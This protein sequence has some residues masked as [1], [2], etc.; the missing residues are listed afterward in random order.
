MRKVCFVG[1]N[2]YELA[3][4]MMKVCKQS[5]RQYK[6][7]VPDKFSMLCELMYFSST[8]TSCTFDTQVVSVSSLAYKVLD[9]L[10]ISIEVL[11][12]QQQ[13]LLV[14]KAIQN[15]GDKLGYIKKVNSSG[16][17]T[18]MSKTI[19]Q[20]K[21]SNVDLSKLQFED[22]KIN[23]FKMI[24]EEYQKL[25]VGKTDNNDLIDLLQKNL[26]NSTIFENT[27]FL[28]VGFDSFT[29][30]IFEVVKT[31]SEVCD[32]YVGAL[33]PPNQ[34]QKSF[35]DLDIYQ[36]VSS[37]FCDVE[38]VM[39]DKTLNFCQAHIE[40]NLFNTQKV[41]T[42]KD[43]LKVYSC[44]AFEDEVEFAFCQ[45]ANSLKD[46]AKPSEISV[47]V[48]NL[49]AHI[50]VLWEKANMYD[51]PVHIEES[52][53]LC[54][55]TLYKFFENIFKLVQSG[56]RAEYIKNFW[57]S[58]FL[59]L[60]IFE[61]GTLVGCCQQLDFFEENFF[62][63]HF[64]TEKYDFYAQYLKDFAKNIKNCK[65]YQQF[66]TLLNDALVFFDCKNRL[67]VFAQQYAQRGFIREEKIFLQIYQKYE[68]AI[69]NFVKVSQDE[70]FDLTSFLDDFSVF[71]Q[72]VKI[73][74]VPIKANSIYVGDATDD[75]F[76]HVKTLYILGAS[77]DSL[78]KSVYDCGLILDKDISSVEG[79][80][81]ITPTIRMIN[82]RN[83]F[84]LFNLCLCPTQNLNVVYSMVDGKDIPCYFVHELLYMFAMAK[85]DIIPSVLFED[86]VSKDMQI[87]NMYLHAINKRIAQRY[88]MQ[89]LEMRFNTKEVTNSLYDAL[90]DVD[91]ALKYLNFDNNKQNIS[92]ASKLFFENGYTKVSEL[93]T[94]FDCPYRHFL[95]YGIKLCETPNCDIDA[96]DI[97][98]V[99]HYICE[100]F[101]KQHG[102][103]F[104]NS[105]IACFVKN[106]F[107][108]IKK[109]EKFWK[110]EINKRNK[111]VLNFL[112]SE[113]HLLCEGLKKHILQ[114][115]FKP[116]KTE[117]MFLQ[118]LDGVKIKG[119]VDRIDKCEECY[120]VIDYKSGN[121]DISEKDVY[122]G[123]KIQPLVYGK[124]V[125]QIFG[126]CSGV[127]LM[128]LKNQKNLDN[129]KLK[130]FY[131]KDVGVVRRMD[132]TLSLENPNSNLI[133]AKFSVKKQNLESGKYELSSTSGKQSFDKMLDYA[134][135]LAKS[136][137]D[138]ISEGLV[139][140]LPLKDSCNFCPYKG[141]CNFDA[142]YGN[143]YRKPSFEF[144]DQS[145]DVD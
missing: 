42:K 142:K 69:Q 59:D 114:S 62:K 64:G 65:D 83:K 92:N 107:E 112:K 38:Y 3:Q 101:V 39:C 37:Q 10:G 6:V 102:E 30:Q 76:A 100:N 139:N 99:L 78:P 82:K 87:Q 105:Q 109:Q 25:C 71:C 40:N 4:S 90:K 103:N 16:F 74:T 138:Q 134:G 1:S 19:S 31:I 85:E 110:F 95:T 116:F 126:N 11:S 144:D 94:F 26:K 86:F 143:T 34:S 89:S 122:I 136:G 24:F 81:Q 131:K 20:L 80:G 18:E 97:G 56:Y 29:N 123:T 77:G 48:A 8:N 125:K 7:V 44:K 115:D 66:T 52:V 145:W 51:L 98:N 113:S 104:D 129:Y 50:D 35:Y 117:Y 2:L 135:K 23:D 132:N 21:S 45:I 73:S 93:E 141:V 72:S 15:C 12:S 36:K 118:E 119:F 46:G 75:F 41:Q 47:A 120:R 137:V 130:G 53:S 79:L 61:R 27:A 9:E 60:E 63:M 84:K 5:G 140:I 55:T 17:Y 28:F 67:E 58:E 111:V 32:I 68:D 96:R 57:Q 13:A 88:L 33:V 127:F 54:D 128:P 133:S 91:N 49:G 70:L 14:K 124:I 22:G 108:D 43:F 121:P 106:A